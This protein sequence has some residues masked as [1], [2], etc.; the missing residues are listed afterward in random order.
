[1]FQETLVLEIHICNF[2]FGDKASF[3]HNVG[4]LN[5]TWVEKVCDKFSIMCKCLNDIFALC[6]FTNP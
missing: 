6:L 1:M 5:G 2:E 3:Q 4:P